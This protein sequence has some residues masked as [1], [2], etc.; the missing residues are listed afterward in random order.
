MDIAARV[1]TGHTMPDGTPGPGPAGVVI[2]SAE[3]GLADTI[4]PRLEAADPD[5]ERVVAI[6]AI[7]D[8]DGERFPALPADL[9]ELGA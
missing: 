5:L 7:T 9:V 1:T 2:L 4:R 6:T 8:G 3:D